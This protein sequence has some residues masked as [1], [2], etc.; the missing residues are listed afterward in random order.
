MIDD[1]EEVFRA[2]N[3][4]VISDG[5]H[6]LHLERNFQARSSRRPCR[7]SKFACDVVDRIYYQYINARDLDSVAN[8]HAVT[9]YANYSR[10]LRSFFS[11][12]Y[13]GPLA[14]KPFRLL[15]ENKAKL[16]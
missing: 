13:N 7:T 12:R 11:V 4:R 8:V 16:V 1:E 6:S 15:R 3:A 2:G 14:T 9:G 5:R 10:A